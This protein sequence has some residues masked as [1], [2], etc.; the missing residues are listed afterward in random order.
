MQEC[1]YRWEGC[2]ANSTMAV[3]LVAGEAEGLF[4]R[5]GH[6]VAGLRC[7]LLVLRPQRRE[8]VARGL[9]LEHELYAASRIWRA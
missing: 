5:R 3:T 2:L 4:G 8:A 7:G 1:E 6:F 9:N